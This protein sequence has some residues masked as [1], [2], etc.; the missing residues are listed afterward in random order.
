MVLD[1]PTSR[2]NGP[3]ITRHMTLVTSKIVILPHQACT[4]EQL[5]KFYLVI[6]FLDI[7]LI[8]YVIWE[9]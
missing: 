7:S 3:T 9:Q 6:P 8:K 2:P 1:N 5:I 4:F